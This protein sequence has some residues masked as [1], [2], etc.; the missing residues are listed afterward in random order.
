MQITHAGQSRDARPLVAGALSAFTLFGGTL[1]G[2]ALGSVV[3]DSLQGHSIAS[4]APA[5]ILVAAVPA[6]LGFLAGG[7]AWGILMGRLAGAHDRKRMAL[8]GM[9]G[10]GPITILLAAGLNLLE[11]LFVQLLGAQLP[12]HRLFTLLFVPSAFL[13][14]GVSAYAIGIGLKDPLRARQLF[15]RVGL[16][17]ALAFLCVNVVMELLGYQVGAPGAGERATMLTV[18]LSGNF[19]AALVGGAVMSRTLAVA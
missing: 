6:L 8:A 3:F 18:M 9:L 16:A 12:I 10:F 7:A 13:I 2:I 11:P 17:A 4:P 19:A 5:H 1:L 15:W 14:A